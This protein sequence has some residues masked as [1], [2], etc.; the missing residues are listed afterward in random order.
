MASIDYAIRESFRL[1]LG[2]PS[3]QELE[4]NLRS[5]VEHN[6]RALIELIADTE[7]SR[8]W[9]RREPSV[10]TISFDAF[11]DGSVS[12]TLHVSAPETTAK[13]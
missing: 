8:E 11:K 5:F 2:E 12:V 9:M 13:G 4:S 6:Q 1:P 7:P 10:V 3:R